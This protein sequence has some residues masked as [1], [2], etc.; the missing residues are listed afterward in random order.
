MVRIV[1]SVVIGACL[2]AEEKA[3]GGEKGLGPPKGRE[4]VAIG[5]LIIAGAAADALLGIGTPSPP[6]QQHTT[7][8]KAQR[9]QE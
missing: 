9:R 5:E 3:M 7:H 1:L 2:G 4:W 8:A 6:K